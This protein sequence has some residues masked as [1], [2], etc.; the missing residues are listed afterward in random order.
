MIKANDPRALTAAVDGRRALVLFHATWCPYCRTFLTTFED[1][2]RT[3]SDWLP[4]ESVLDDED[5]PL[6]DEYG[7]DVVPTLI[8]FENGKP[9][10][11]ADA[12]PGIGL[13]AGDLGRL[14]R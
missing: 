3:A 5:N 8:L 14:L 6:W 12:L 4:V 13:T 11:R 9:A 1:V 10:R 7:V 2:A